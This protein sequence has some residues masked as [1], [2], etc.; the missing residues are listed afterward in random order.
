MRDVELPTLGSLFGLG[1]EPDGHEVLFGFSSFTVPPSVY[2]LDPATGRQSCGV[3]WR[4]T[5]TPNG[6]A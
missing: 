5:S 6:F 3:G 2:R 1:M 4:P